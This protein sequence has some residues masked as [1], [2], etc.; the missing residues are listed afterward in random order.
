[1]FQLFGAMA[2]F[3]RGLI[4]ERTKAGLQAARGRGVRLGRRPGLSPAQVGHAKV[5]LAS[6]ESASVVARSLGVG[7]S[8]LY[9]SLGP[10]I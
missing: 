6:G 8:T 2:E 10:Q 7:R 4:A 9:R 3:E 1:M 5:L